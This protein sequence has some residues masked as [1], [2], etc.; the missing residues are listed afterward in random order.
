MKFFVF[1]ANKLL[2][3]LCRSDRFIPGIKQGLL[4]FVFF[5][6]IALYC[7][8]Q[9]Q[10]PFNDPSLSIEIRVNDL[11]GRLTLEE[12]TSLMLY[13]SPA[14]PRLGIP[15]Y[16]WW[17]ECLHGVARNGIATVFPQAI[18]L[19]A[20]FD[21]ALIRKVA[22]AISDEAR[23]KYYAARKDGSSGQYAGLSFWTPNI[24]IFR[25][26]RWGRGQETYGEDPYLTGM[27]GLSFVRG[28]QGDDPKYLKAAACAKHFAVHSGPEPDRHTFNAIVDEK[29]LR[30]TYLPAFKTLVDGHVEAVM[31]AYNRV[32][33]EPCCGSNTLLHNIL[34]NEWHFTGHVVSDC[35]ALDDIWARHKVVETREEACAMA[36]KAGVNLNCGYIYQYIPAAVKK[37]LITEDDVNQQLSILLH[38]RFRL[39]LFDPDSL[40]PW[41]DISPD[42]INS[43]GNRALAREAAGKSIILARNRNN[44]LP[45]KKDIH[46]LF[47]TGPN[48]ADA[49]VLLGNYNGLSDNLV[50]ILEGIM[51]K[52]SNSTKVEYIKGTDLVKP[53]YDGWFLASEYDATIAVMGISP[54]LEGEEGD[55]QL[56]EARGDRK[57]IELPENQVEYIKKLRGDHKKPLILV[58]T[59]G[60]PVTLTG[61]DTLAD[62]ILY[63][64]YPGEEGGNA[65][66]DVIF[67]DINPAGRFP[68]TVLK[69]TAD[70]PP[71]ADYSMKNRTYRYYLGEPEFPFGFGLSFT[72]FSYSDIQTNQDDLLKE[73]MIKISCKV[74][75]TGNVDGDEVVQLYVRKIDP[76]EN[77]PVKSLKGFSRR[78]ITK[79][80]SVTV[81][82]LLHAGDLQS[83]NTSLNSWE[84]RPGDY[85]IIVGASSADTRLTKIMHIQ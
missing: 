74:K 26:P 54:L 73:G 83:W 47:I 5:Q 24:N 20:T 60:G 15:A 39:G 22:S 58:I 13:N 77:D 78:F 28:L 85:E 8:S 17:N 65:V 7:F 29:D 48:A 46:T 44:T 10:F 2:F 61:I 57:T 75:N 21:T 25:D 71:F 32:N 33:D 31:C 51:K 43:P 72:T 67:G 52:V 69:S 4:L 64:G 12:K 27:L 81:E 38:T 59:G 84:V 70:L 41:S 23:A 55:A 11:V 45:L 49:S 35:W 19:A 42:V 37:G 76:D 18:G 9:E 6:L 30:E 1:S 3:M 80:G 66:A 53:A 63:V 56:S 14:I 50:T 34:R 82:F 62:A 16:N 79:G 68:V 36:M 40:V